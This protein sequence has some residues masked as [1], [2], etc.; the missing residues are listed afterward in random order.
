M[1]FRAMGAVEIIL[2][3]S[4]WGAENLEQSL[5][6]T[7]RLREERIKPPGDMR[8]ISRVWCHGANKIYFVIEVQN[9]PFGI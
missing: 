8:K 7:Q 5:G 2:G 3:G 6:E 9:G 4:L 1:V